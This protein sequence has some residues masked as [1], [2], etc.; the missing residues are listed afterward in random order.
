MT[1]QAN[2]TRQKDARLIYDAT[3]EGGGEFHPSELYRALR[4]QNPNLD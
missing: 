4:G 2:K 3:S 1:K